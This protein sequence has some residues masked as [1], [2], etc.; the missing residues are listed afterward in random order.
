M[1]EKRHVVALSGGKD[2]TA[3]ALRL[4][5]TVPRDY[6]YFCTPTGN[7]PQALVDH[8]NRLEHLLG[9]PITYVTNGTLVGLIEKFDAL[10]NH[11]QRWC[12]RILKIEPCIAFLA[13]VAP[14]VLYV[15]LRAD[16]PPEERAGIYGNYAEYR[17][18]LREW[19]W[20]LR[21]V[22]SFL[23]ER[24]VVIPK[25]TDCKWCFGQRLIEWKRLLLEDP[26]AYEEAVQ[27][28]KK[29]GHTFR[30]PTRDSWPASLADLRDEFLSGRKVRGEDRAEENEADQACR[31]CSL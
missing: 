5:E 14:A 24:G 7:E 2:S 31:V 18:P 4:K 13:K 28:E 17:Y 8:W 1:I 6:I 23:K 9:A 26:V 3:L 27:L 22:L 29:M 20:N 15:G 16:E 30:S 11:R 19:G 21:E 12:T 25:R 10:P